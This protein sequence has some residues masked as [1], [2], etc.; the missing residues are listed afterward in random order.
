MF[1]FHPGGVNVLYCDGHVAFLQEELEKVTLRK[2]LTREEGD[3]IGNGE[4]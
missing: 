2:I 1:G 4:L 3:L